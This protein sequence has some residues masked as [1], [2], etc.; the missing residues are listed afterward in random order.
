MEVVTEGHIFSKSWGTM[1]NSTPGTL[2]LCTGYCCFT[3]AETALLPRSSHGKGRLA[4]TEA[5]T[6]VGHGHEPVLAGVAS[7][8]CADV[9]ACNEYIQSSTYTRH[10]YTLCTGLHWSPHVVPKLKWQVRLA[11]M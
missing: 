9:V 2:A 3:A 7:S 8:A 4:L 10:L 6:S 11:V 5:V 1:A